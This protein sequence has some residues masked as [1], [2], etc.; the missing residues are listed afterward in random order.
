MSHGLTSMT[1][2]SAGALLS[3]APIHSLIG[4]LQAA[5][6]NIA[7]GFTN[8]VSS[9]YAALLPTADIATALVTSMPS[10]DFNLFMSGIERAVD[11]DLLGGL[12]YA[13]VAPLAADAALARLGGGWE[14]IIVVNAIVLGLGGQLSA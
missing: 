7:N 12:E 9:A 14:L 5:N 4:Q 6:T 2:P 10:Y 1:L 11:G 13:L 3:P 8:A